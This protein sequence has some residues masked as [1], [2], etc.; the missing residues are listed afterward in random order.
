MLL[1]CCCNID[2]IVLLSRV[3]FQPLFVGSAVSSFHLLESEDDQ[4]SSDRKVTIQLEG[5]KPIVDLHVDRCG[6]T[7]YFL[8]ALS[9]TSAGNSRNNDCDE[10]AEKDPSSCALV[11]EVKMVDGVK[12]LSVHSQFCVFNNGARPIR[13]F[14]RV[15]E[16]GGQAWVPL[17]RACDKEFSFVPADGHYESSERIE[18]QQEHS[19]SRLI[20]C[21]ACRPESKVDVY[22][23]ASAE[24]ERFEGDYHLCLDVQRQHIGSCQSYVF[25]RLASPFTIENLLSSSVCIRVHQCNS[26]PTFTIRLD[27]A[28]NLCPSGNAEKVRPYCTF[29]WEEFSRDSSKHSRSRTCEGADP[30]WNDS[31]SLRWDVVGTYAHRIVGVC[32][33]L[34][35]YLVRTTVFSARHVLVVECFDK[36][37]PRSAEMLGRLRLN[38]DELRELTIPRTQVPTRLF[39]LEPSKK[40]KSLSSSIRGQLSMSFDFPNL[41]DTMHAGIVK[42]RFFLFQR[43]CDHLLLSRSKRSYVRD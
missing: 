32:L 13:L 18:L 28:S 31:I 33:R 14:G 12:T 9:D 6:S 26:Q 41:Q 11:A 15:V 36:H 19:S 29:F 34:F 40:S 21:R 8:Q 37:A 35:V 38:V 27:S 20:V 5:F 17:S 24:H 7:V 25:F 42:H 39:Q 22:S 3:F 30:T 16:S 1:C 4:A 2:R 10:D 43:V 23:Q